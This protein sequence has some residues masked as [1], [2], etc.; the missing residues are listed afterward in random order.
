MTTHK[1][2]ARTV[3]L[4]RHLKSDWDD[5]SLADFDRPLA[6]RGKASG[7]LIAPALSMRCPKPDLILCSPARRTYDTLGYILRELTQ[8]EAP[9]IRV[10]FDPRIYDTTANQLKELISEIPDTISNIL[11]IG[12]NPAMLDLAW[13]FSEDP[14]QELSIY[15]KFPT[16]GV[17]SYKLDLES[18]KNIHNAKGTSL[19]LFTPKTLK[20]EKSSDS[21]S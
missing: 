6:P 15:R 3:T 5:P 1:I 10:Q 12:H 7:L 11:L 9:K 20:R 16:G 8:R 18:W 2:P 17:A 14:D 21:L 13:F 4:L 19:S